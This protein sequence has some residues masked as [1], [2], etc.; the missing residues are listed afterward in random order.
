MWASVAGTEAEDNTRSVCASLSVAMPPAFALALLF[1]LPPEGRPLF[2]WGARPAVIA[3]TPVPSG[4]TEAHVTEVHAA[5][6]Q[7]DLFVRFTFDRS[8]RDVL[9]SPEGQP[10]SGRLRARLYID[11]DGDRK[12]GLDEGPGDLRT[13]AEARLDLGVVAM[14]EDAEEKLEARALVTVAVVGLTPPGRRRTLWRADDDANPQQVSAHGDAVEVR[15]P[16]S[17]LKLQPRARIVLTAA[18]KVWDGLLTR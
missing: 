10:I 8:V 17:V 6:E 2:Y 7:N 9:Y 3:A 15:V 12:S 18:E 1:L 4:G 16:G 13:G 11:A 5:V 14:G